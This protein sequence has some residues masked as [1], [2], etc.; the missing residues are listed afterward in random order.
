MVG[1][2]ITILLLPFSL[3]PILF[4]AAMGQKH[5]NKPQSLTSK[6]FELLN[7]AQGQELSLTSPDW[8]QGY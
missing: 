3:P 4:S 6:H 8:S 7:G 1:K 5:V 2:G